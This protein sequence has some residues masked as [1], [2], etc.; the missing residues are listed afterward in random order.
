M[1]GAHNCFLTYHY[2][3]KYLSSSILTIIAPTL[4][5][6]SLHMVL[7]TGMLTSHDRIQTLLAEADNQPLFHLTI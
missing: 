6:C 3:I 2:I 5:V 7:S 1:K 4:P